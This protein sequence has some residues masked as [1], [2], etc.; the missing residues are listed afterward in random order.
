MWAIRE[1]R[2]CQL[3]CLCLLH[4]LQTASLGEKTMA[5]IIDEEE[6]GGIRRIALSKVGQFSVT[7]VLS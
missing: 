4:G 2:H 6:P 3:H 1:N 7:T 5:G